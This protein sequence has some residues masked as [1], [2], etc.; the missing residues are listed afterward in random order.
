VLVAQIGPFTAVLE[1]VATA[2]GAGVVL[3]GT[4]AG[5]VGFALRK[6]RQWTEH[7]VLF[8]GYGG[9]ALGAGLALA[10]FILRYGVLK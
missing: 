7:T 3:S 6:P 8:A 4:L 5:F 10:D 9:G 2:V 1:A